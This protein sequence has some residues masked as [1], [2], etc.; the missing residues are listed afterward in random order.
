MKRFIV[1]PDSFKESLSSVEAAGHIASG[2]RRVW[3]DAE[4]VEAPLADG[5]EGM[6]NTMV[7]ASG[8][9]VVSREVTGPLGNPVKASYG[10]LG[11]GETAV[12]EMAAASGLG[13]VPAGRRNPMA[14]TTFGTGELIK[15]ALDEGCRRLIVGIG[16]SA[17][18]DGGAGM[19][20]ALGVRL[21]DAEGKEIGYGAAGLLCL[22]RIDSTGLDYRIG[23]TEVLVACDV[24]NP[25][26]GPEGAAYVYG[27]QKG[28]APEMLPVLDR[29]LEHLAALVRRDLGVEIRQLPGAG[30]AGGLGGGL[31]A[32]LGG[33]LRRGIDIVFEALGFESLLAGGADLVITGEGEINGQTVYGKVPVGVARLAKKYNLP[34]LAIAGSIGPGAEKV[35]AE[36]IDA[37]MSIITRPMSLEEAVRQAPGLV[38]DAAERALRIMSL[39]PGRL[40]GNQ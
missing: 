15:A 8:G 10:L 35:L 13:L 30:A 22:S 20:Q 26:C 33:R 36:G 7:A 16:G 23:K 28:A 25:L 2:I 38:A 3:P 32:F 12:V 6:L 4:I 34:V 40:P 39:A 17:T 37:Y 21:P 19:A 5:G 1:A 24:D 18:N 11:D 9:R 27:P 14:T 29:A 31:A